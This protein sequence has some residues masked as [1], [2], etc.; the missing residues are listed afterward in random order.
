MSIPADM[1]RDMERERNFEKNLRNK[2][3]EAL[4]RAIANSAVQKALAAKQLDQLAAA[5][6]GMK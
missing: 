4:C 1:L 3:R 5:L 2:E 6:K